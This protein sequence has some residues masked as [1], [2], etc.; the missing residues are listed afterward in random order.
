MDS[1]ALLCNCAMEIQIYFTNTIKNELIT[2]L[3]IIFLKCTLRFNSMTARMTP[4]RQGPRINT[5]TTNPTGAQHCIGVVATSWRRIGVDTALFRRH[6]SSEKPLHPRQIPLHQALWKNERE[7]YQL[8]N[9]N[10]SVLWTFLL[11][12]RIVCCTIKKQ[13]QKKIIR[14]SNLYVKRESV[15][16]LN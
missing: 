12:F 16:P 7:T 6:V 15:F 10:Y 2:R 1:F 3:K 9:F 13:K 11:V 14:V 5:L 8:T 4:G